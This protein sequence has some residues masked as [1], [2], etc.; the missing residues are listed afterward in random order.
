MLIFQDTRMSN[1]VFNF[2]T[3]LCFLYLSH[4]FISPYFSKI[5]MLTFFHLFLIF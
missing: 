3:D 4:G 2:N 1:E 5:Y